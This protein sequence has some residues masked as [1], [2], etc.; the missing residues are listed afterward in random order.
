M[1][2][3]GR[4][5]RRTI[6]L[7]SRDSESQFNPTLAS[8]V[9]KNDKCRILNFFSSTILG[10]LHI[11]VIW[12]ISMIYFPGEETWL[13]RRWIN[14]EI[15]N[16][17]LSGRLSTLKVRTGLAYV[18]ENNRKSIWKIELLTNAYGWPA[19]LGQHWI[20]WKIM[21]ICKWTPVNGCEYFIFFILYTLHH[22]ST[23]LHRVIIIGM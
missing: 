20:T 12:R 11:I 13:G 21:T 6:L 5:S 10:Y 14:Q 18:Y 15:D 23:P 7:S 16:Y 17:Q 1:T 8:R 22:L 2:A 9:Y 4:L 3:V 19:G